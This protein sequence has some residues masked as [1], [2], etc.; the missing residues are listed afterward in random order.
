[1]RQGANSTIRFSVY[2][3]LKSKAETHYPINPSTQIREIPFWI[4]FGNGVLAGLVTV[5]TTQ[6]LDVLKTKM[7]K[8]T[9]KLDYTNSWNCLLKTIRQEGLLSLW[10]GTT[11]RLSRLSVSGAIVFTIYEEFLLLM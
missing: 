6:P 7:Q 9:A 5:L 1:M 11:P 8:S 10:K 2:G 4:H 3:S